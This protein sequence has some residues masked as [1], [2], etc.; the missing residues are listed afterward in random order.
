[1][2]RKHSPE[3]REKLRQAALRRER[4]PRKRRSKSVHSGREV[5]QRWFP[6][7]ELCERCKKAP[8]IDRHHIDGNTHNNV[9]DNLMMLCRRCHQ[10][11]DGRLGRLKHVND[12]RKIIAHCKQ[13]HILN[14]KRQCIVCRRNAVRRYKARKLAQVEQ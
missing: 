2:G 4:K 12:W 9:R 6:L 3:T 14:E 7:P 10:I 8:P 1:M 5:A 11:V 13:G